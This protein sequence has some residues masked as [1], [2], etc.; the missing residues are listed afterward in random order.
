M[1]KLQWKIRKAIR[2]S[3]PAEMTQTE[4]GDI[5]SSVMAVLYAEE[6]AKE[7]QVS[8]EQQSRGPQVSDPWTNERYS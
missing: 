2:D 1:L 7:V 6:A 5:L 3:A 8:E 4:V